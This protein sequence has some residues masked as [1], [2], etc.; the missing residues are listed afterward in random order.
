MFA[1]IGMNSSLI[2]FFFISVNLYLRNATGD[3]VL[4]KS[5][6]AGSFTSGVRYFFYAS[7]DKPKISYEESPDYREGHYLTLQIDFDEFPEEIGTELFLDDERIFY[8]PPGYYYPDVL[9]TTKERISIPS[10]FHVYT[11]IIGD[12]FG[13]GFSGLE[14]TGY[15][16]WEGDVETGTLIA[17]GDFPYGYSKTW[18]FTTC[19]LSI[20]CDNATA[21]NYSLVS[22]NAPD[23]SLTLPPTATPVD[24]DLSLTTA[25]PLGIIPRNVSAF[26]KLFV[27]ESEPASDAV[28]S[29]WKAMDYVGTS[30]TWMASAMFMFLATV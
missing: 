7:F 18:I 9:A 24:A 16:L 23:P 21:A 22:S 25:P 1:Y 8:R 15:S 28:S 17:Q 6:E 30:W 26:S 19:D 3:D 14:G 12:T 27:N 20:G 2:L 5:F 10:S 13:D 11:F 4:L 29:A